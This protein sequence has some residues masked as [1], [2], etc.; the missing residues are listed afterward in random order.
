MEAIVRSRER[1][2][3]FGALADHFQ[4]HL[5]PSRPAYVSVLLYDSQG[6]RAKFSRS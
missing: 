5:E 6:K 3:K 4:I 1:R 2:A